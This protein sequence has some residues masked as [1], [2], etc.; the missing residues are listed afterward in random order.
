MAD[1]LVVAARSMVYGEDIVHSGPVY[2]G[3]A[4]NGNEIILTFDHIGNGLIARA[5]NPEGAVEIADALTGF[6]ICG[7]DEIFVSAQAASSGNTVIVASPGVTEP[8][9]VRYG[10]TGLP[11]ANLYNT[12]DIFT[13][14]GE[15]FIEALPA[16][17]F[18]T[19]TFTIQEYTEDDPN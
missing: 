5:G 8:V 13:R 4:I 15:P 12:V 19:D 14:T 18:R 1:R 17:P 7:S 2:N 3:M 16:S 11:S 10:W 9:A 6:T